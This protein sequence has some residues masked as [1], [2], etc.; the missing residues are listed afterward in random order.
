MNTHPESPSDFQRILRERAR[1]L[2]QPPRVE[3]PGDTREFVVA[4]LSD[5]HYGFAVE[6]VLEILKADGLTVLPGGPSFWVGLINLRGRLAPVLD[7][8]AW[9]G[10]A[11]M[12]PGQPGKIIIVGQ[13]GLVAG[14]LVDDVPALR[15]VPV[16]Q[17]GPPLAPVSTGDS[18]AIV[19]LTTDL[20][21]IIDLRKL[22]SDPRLVVQED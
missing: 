15:S 4:A 3:A 21:A 9:L 8:R 12:P 1:R 7:L 17:I 16:S 22:L 5:E 14:L 6:D 18:Q 11:P 20:L 10:L 19:G 13:A 2:A